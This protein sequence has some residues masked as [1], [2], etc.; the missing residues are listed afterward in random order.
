ML[1]SCTFD[2]SGSAAQSAGDGWTT[3]MG[4]TGVPTGTADTSEPPDRDLPDSSSTSATTG[5]S[6]GDEPS[7]LDDDQLLVRYYL[8][9]ASQG[10]RR[11]VARDAAPQPLHLDHRWVP[12][13]V[14]A[15]SE[16]GNKGLQWTASGVDG[17]PSQAIAGTKV[18]DRLHG[19]TAVTIEAVVD[20]EESTPS[21]FIL[22]IGHGAG[23]GATI[24][25]LGLATYGAGVLILR[26]DNAVVGHWT[27]DLPGSERAV[28]HLVLD[29]TATEDDRVRL[30]LSGQRLSGE[31]HDD[32]PSDGQELDLQDDCELVLGNRPHDRAA[33]IGGTLYYA[34]LYTK[35]FDDTQVA[36]HSDVLL[37]ND[38]HP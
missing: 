3:A 7:T 38:D 29:T 4:S 10:Q 16:D 2:S 1:V 22:A 24:V 37:V 9:E 32:W 20:V 27:V 11:D 13:V 23:N 19:Q 8:D 21:S 26:L 30:Y 15:A 17:G 6:T 5:G 12:E 33:S 18:L 34:A 36:A 28:L 35:A 31:K 14:Y 25:K